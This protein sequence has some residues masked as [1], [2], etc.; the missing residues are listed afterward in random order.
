MAKPVLMFLLEELDEA[1]IE[2]IILVVGPDELA[3]FQ[4]AFSKSIGEEHM[5]KL[6]ERVREYE[7]RILEIGKKIRFV[8]QKNRMGFGHAVYQARQCLERE[9]VLLLLGDFIYKSNQNL[10][11]VR[12]TINAYRKS[13]GQ[14]TVAIKEISLSDV[15]HYGVISGTF[16][17][18]QFLM[19]ANEMCEKPTVEYARDYLS[20]RKSNNQESYYA[21]FGQYVLTP[22]VFD[23]L[24]K[25]ISK[26]SEDIDGR[27]IQMTD[28]F[29]RILKTKGMTGVVV[30]GTSFDVGIPEAYVK[31]AGSFFGVG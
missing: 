23:Y 28:T 9:P 10:T 17:S 26:H 20:V 16:N 1:G 7:R 14:L 21:T 31:T 2:E 22:E 30:D 25:E 24:E 13:G 8:V 15:V 27:E 12:Q 6:S 3:Y 19:T 11:C 4:Q 5:S 29:Q 18:D